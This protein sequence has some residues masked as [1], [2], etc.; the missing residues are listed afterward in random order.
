MNM[1]HEELKG[2]IEPFLKLY[3]LAK[4]KGMGIKQIVNLLEIANN[5]L[6]DIEERFKTLRNDESTLQFRKHS[7]ERNLY[8]LNNKIVSTTKLLNSLRMSCRRKRREIE[9]LYNEKI[10]LEAIITGFKSSNEE[11]LK[12]K[13]TAEETVKSVLNDG[14]ILLKFATLSVIE[15]LRSNPELYNFVL[16]NILN[17]NAACYGSNY[18]SLVS[19]QRQQQSFN[20]SYI[21]LILEESEKLYNMLITEFT[22]RVIAT[23][24][25]MRASLLAS[26]AD[27]NDQ[28][29]TYKIDNTYQ[30]EESKYNN[31]SSL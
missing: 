4:R 17:S 1:V 11:Y 16:Y 21:A 12:I 3:K 27:N 10:R 7:L 24:A 31:P 14:K 26:P 6:P 8:Q 25:A 19:K 30:T 23:A 5:D 29:L 13:Q 9:K 2:D 22:N 15:S 20:D 18:P 28:K